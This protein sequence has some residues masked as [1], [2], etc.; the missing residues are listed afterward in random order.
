MRGFA[1]AGSIGLITILA[2]MIVP[3]PAQAAGVSRTFTV[4]LTNAEGTGAP[5]LPSAAVAAHPAYPTGT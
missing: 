1:R 3:A 5:S 4:A 2:G